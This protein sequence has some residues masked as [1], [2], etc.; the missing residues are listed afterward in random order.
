MLHT[1]QTELSEHWIV[2][3]MSSECKL[4]RRDY[5]RCFAAFNSLCGPNM[6]VLRGWAAAMEASRAHD[7]L[8]GNGEGWSRS[9]TALNP[10]PFQHQKQVYVDQ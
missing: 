1:R 2:V 6:Q 3:V 5:Q 4:A 10:A 7:R 9:G 8:R